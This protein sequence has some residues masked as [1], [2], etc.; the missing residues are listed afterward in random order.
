MIIQDRD[1]G[2]T[3][4][5][6]SARKTVSS[7]YKG[8][9]PKIHVRYMDPADLNPP[10]KELPKDRPLPV[11]PTIASI[12]SSDPVSPTAQSPAFQVDISYEGR[13]CSQKS[14]LPLTPIKPENPGEPIEPSQVNEPEVELFHPKLYLP[15]DNYYT[16]RG[17]YAKYESACALEDFISS[18]LQSELR[19]KGLTDWDLKHVA[20]ALNSYAAGRDKG[21]KGY[22]KYLQSLQDRFDMLDPDRKDAQLN[23]MRYMVDSAANGKLIAVDDT[24]DKKIQAAMESVQASLA[25]APK[26]KKKSQ[27]AT[28]ATNTN[29]VAAFQI[30]QQGAKNAE[31][32]IA[33]LTGTPEKNEDKSTDLSSLTLSDDASTEGDAPSE[34]RSALRDLN[35]ATSGKKGSTGAADAEESPADEYSVT[36]EDWIRVSRKYAEEHTD[37]P[38][39][40]T[41]Y[42]RDLE[43]AEDGSIRKRTDSVAKKDSP[44]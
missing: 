30:A 5:I 36:E 4:A 34:F 22:D 25:E 23:L 1:R 42:F 3:E 11:A 17:I 27:P 33:A 8:K 40:N 37:V 19:E 29:D 9:F 35:H 32:L 18:S 41:D 20:R 12:T 43:Y 28:P 14:Q 26:K 7:L 31:D 6:A 10:K 13:A 21:E 15:S 2:L 16:D 24:L 44:V 38:I 39:V